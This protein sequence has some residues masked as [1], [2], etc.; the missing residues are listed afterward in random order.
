MFCPKIL[1]VSASINT[2]IIICYNSA[3]PYTNRCLFSESVGGSNVFLKF[4]VVI[5]LIHKLAHLKKKKKFKENEEKKQQQPP[6]KTKN[7]K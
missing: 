2:I 3:A 4:S 1:Y 5:I 6:K 7:K